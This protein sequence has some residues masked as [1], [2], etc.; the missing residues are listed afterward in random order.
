MSKPSLP[1][2]RSLSL[3]DQGGELLFQLSW[4]EPFFQNK[5]KRTGKGD[6]NA[7]Q[8]KSFVYART[9][10]MKEVFLMSYASIENLPF[11]DLLPV[12]KPS[13]TKPPSV[14]SPADSTDPTNNT[15]STKP[16]PTKKK[17]KLKVSSCWRHGSYKGDGT[18]SL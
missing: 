8:K 5:N 17:I 7:E 9:H 1:L 12:Q 10:L 2:N 11:S 14:L 6:K 3:K 18:E 13:P 4:S 15:S 16:N